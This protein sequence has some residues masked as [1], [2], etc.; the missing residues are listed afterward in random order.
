M[1]NKKQ[2]EEQT[3]MLDGILIDPWK[4]EVSQIRV[5][6]DSDVWRKVLRCDVFDCMCI[7]SESG[8]TCMDLWFDDEGRLIEPPSP[9]F[10]LIRGDSVGGGCYDF[11]GY[12]LLLSSREGTTIGL[13]TTP[14][15]IAM[16][17]TMC[18]LSF[19]RLEDNPRFKGIDTDFIEQ[20][21]R[22]I[23]L[24][25]PGQFQ[26]IGSASICEG[27]G[28]GNI[29]IPKNILDEIVDMLM[30]EDEEEET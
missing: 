21:M 5:S 16:W 4:E 25:L 30:S 22:S 13:T 28:P 2:N 17:M 19:E 8:G 14:A 1:K 27:D 18:E 24:E 23:E 20:K 3:K 6:S 12:G 26:L 29:P 15:S 10:R 9:R 7:S 11:C